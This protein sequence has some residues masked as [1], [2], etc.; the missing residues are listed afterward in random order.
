[1]SLS[2]DI[3]LGLIKQYFYETSTH[4]L[5]RPQIG[6]RRGT[7]GRHV[8]LGVVCSRLSCLSCHTCNDW[9]HNQDRQCP[10]TVLHFPAWHNQHFSSVHPRAHS[11]RR[12]TR[13]SRQ[14]RKAF[15]S[16]QT[17]A[18]ASYISPVDWV[19]TLRTC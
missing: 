6:H 7:Q 5:L 18:R 19:M 16:L 11:T 2:L 12:G 15:C 10:R 3:E 1:M 8:Q 17:C 13:T 4:Q 9:S 14:A